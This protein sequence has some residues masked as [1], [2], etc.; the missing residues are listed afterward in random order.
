MIK[1]IICILVILSLAGILGCSLTS[2]TEAP[3]APSSV[4]TIR[5]ANIASEWA[6]KQLEINLESEIS[7]MLRLAEGDKV[8]GYYYLE[9]GNNIG[10]KITGNSLV[11]ESKTQGT[12]GQNIN[13]DRF[14]F[15]ASK[16]QGIAY[17]LTLTTPNDADKGR[18][19][20]TVFMEIIYPASASVFV[21]IGTK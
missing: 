19:G 12:K 11:F 17:S 9:K 16:E 8:D 7:I 1:K 14:S 5:E 13:S 21:P 3:P 15:I 4:K 2:R 6:V 20:T 10:F 18:D